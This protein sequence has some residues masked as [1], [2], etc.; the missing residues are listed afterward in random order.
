MEGDGVGGRE[1][2]GWFDSIAKS[3][4]FSQWAVTHPHARLSSVPSC[5]AIRRSG[6]HGP[7][8]TLMLLIQP[9]C[10]QCHVCRFVGVGGARKSGRPENEERRGGWEVCGRVGDERMW[11]SRGRRRMGWAEGEMVG[12]R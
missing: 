10:L 5:C 2:S 1:E 11:V 7:P 4:S 3:P 6:F 9:T 8:H 12:G